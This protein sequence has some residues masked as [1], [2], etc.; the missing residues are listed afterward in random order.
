MGWTSLTIMMTQGT[1]VSAAN[2]CHCHSHM[3]QTWVRAVFERLRVLTLLRCAVVPTLS[4]AE[5][6]PVVADGR[7]KERS[8]SSR[9]ALD[10]VKD[11]L[12]PDCQKVRLKL[13]CCQSSCCESYCTTRTASWE[14]CQNCAGCTHVVVLVATCSRH[15]LLPAALRTSAP[16]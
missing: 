16:C 14:R 11:Y 5:P 12:Q 1:K 2:D 9:E 3:L 13:Q 15:S 7:P 6:V 10:A 8:K 4:L